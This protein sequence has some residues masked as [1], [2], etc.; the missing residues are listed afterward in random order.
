MTSHRRSGE[1]LTTLPALMWLLLFFVVPTLIVFAF[2]FKPNDIAGGIGPGWTLDAFRSVLSSN[3]FTIIV[4]TLWLSLLTGA[5]SLVL[6]LPMAYYIAR[7]KPKTQQLIL[8]LVIMPF[9]SSF[10]VRIFA[11][12]SL[13][14]PEGFVKQLLVAVVLATPDTVLLYSVGTVLLVMVYSY[15]PFAILPLYAAAAK[16]NFQLFEAAMDLG[17]TRLQVFFRIFIPCMRKGIITAFIMVFIPAVGAYVIPDIVGGSSTE[18]IGNK[19]VQRTFI[20][21]NLPQASALST[22]LAAAVALPMLLIGLLQLRTSQ[23]GSR[24]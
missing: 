13:L 7:T 2:A 5:I 15:L 3:Y 24:E 14:H 23:R 20:D 4:R 6:A 12:K 8:L 18:M 22:L 17:M 11:W 16:F 21:R 9:W 19:I 10:L 1:L